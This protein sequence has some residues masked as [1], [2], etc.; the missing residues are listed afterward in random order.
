VKSTKNNEPEIGFEQICFG[1]NREIDEQSLAIFL[2]L[3][4]RE[5]LLRTLIPRLEDDEIKQIVQQLTGV[6]HKHLQEK[7][8]HELF[9]GDFE[10]RH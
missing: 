4:T 7:E 1:L 8:Y 3:F 5:R 2:R 9:L 10:H 6:L